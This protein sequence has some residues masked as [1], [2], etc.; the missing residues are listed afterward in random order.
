MTG[1]ILFKQ[2]YRSRNLPGTAALN[3]RHLEYIATRPGAV[4][5]PGCGFS[6]WGRLPGVSAP[7]QINDLRLAREIVR[8]ASGDHTLWRVILSTDDYRFDG[9]G[10]IWHQTYET[11]ERDGKPGIRMYLPSRTAA[12]LQK[13]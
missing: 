12:V 7:E 8:T 6:L 11:V 10:R 9:H 3:V 13:A 4:P 5:N 2:R 1:G